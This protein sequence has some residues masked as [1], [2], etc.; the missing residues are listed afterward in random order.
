MNEETSS[1]TFE[2]D[3]TRLDL[4]VIHRTGVHAESQDFSRG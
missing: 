2:V 1:Q 4:G 3:A